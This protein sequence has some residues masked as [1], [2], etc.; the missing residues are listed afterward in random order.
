MKGILDK[1]F[2]FNF[3]HCFRLVFTLLSQIK[4]TNPSQ[5]LIDLWFYLV[6]MDILT[7]GKSE[8]AKSSLRPR[9]KISLQWPV[10]LSRRFAPRKGRLGLETNFRPRPLEILLSPIS[11]RWGS[12]HYF[13]VLRYLLVK[14]EQET[15][16]SQNSLC[17]TVSCKTWRLVSTRVWCERNYSH[18]EFFRRKNVE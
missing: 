7:S 18:N 12:L 2:I 8:T 10:S 17:D 11:Q 16:L 15:L 1:K 4:L 14:S 13:W 9:S 3:E 5:N 6:V